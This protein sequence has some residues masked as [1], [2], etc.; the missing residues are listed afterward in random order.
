MELTPK[1]VTDLA[2]KCFFDDED[3]EKYDG[4][5]P[6]ELW[7]VGGGVARN[8]IFDQRKIEKHKSEIKELLLQLPDEFMDKEKGGISFVKMPFR[9]D[10][11]QWGEQKD[12]ELL[13]ALGKAAG[14]VW[15]TPRELW[16]LTL[17]V[18]IVQ[19]LQNK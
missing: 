13:M 18:P 5:P 19:V 14:M 3:I 17:G 9:K 12:A 4:K 7:A 6:L 16:P 10:G 2:F 1:N 8:L 11:T 15:Y